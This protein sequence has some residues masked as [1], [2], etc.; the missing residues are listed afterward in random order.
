M[1]YPVLEEGYGADLR[2]QAHTLGSPACKV[3]LSRATLADGAPYEHTITV[4]YLDELNG[5]VW[6]ILGEYDGDNPPTRLGI[7]MSA[8][9]LGLPT[10]PDDRLPHPEIRCARCR[11]LDP[12]AHDHD[13]YCR[14]CRGDITTV[15]RVCGD[16]ANLDSNDEC[17]TCRNVTADEFDALLDLL[18]DTDR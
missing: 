14:A 3:W 16:A 4:E 6:R 15:C 7:T 8:A 12:T 17:D 5:Y 1:Q 18:P 11:R 13:G 2:W 10:S 9:W